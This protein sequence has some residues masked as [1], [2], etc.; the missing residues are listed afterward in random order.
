[1]ELRLEATQAEEEKDWIEHIHDVRKDGSAVSMW[2]ALMKRPFTK[3]LPSEVLE[4]MIE[5]FD[6]NQAWKYLKDLSLTR[7]Q[8]KR[9]MNSCDGLRTCTPGKRIAR[10][11]SSKLPKMVKSFWKL[12]FRGQKLGI[13]TNAPP[14]VGL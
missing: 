6:P 12:T 8:G 9:L 2:K 14:C 5:G 11:T 4:L 10:P 1:M 7:K 3:D 13:L